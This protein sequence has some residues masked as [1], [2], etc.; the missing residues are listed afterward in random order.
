MMPSIK[1][2][3]AEGVRLSDEEI[4]KL[5]FELMA[6]KDQLAAQKKSAALLLSITEARARWTE[7]RKQRLT[8]EIRRQEANGT[9]PPKDIEI[10]LRHNEFDWTR[11]RLENEVRKAGYEV[12]S[13]TFKRWLQEWMQRKKIQAGGKIY[14]TPEQAQLFIESIIPRL[15]ARKKT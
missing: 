15:E 13:S 14:L 2:I 5:N 3:L 12:P 8:A 4:R 9:K 6:L 7:N 10:L 11:K 1:E